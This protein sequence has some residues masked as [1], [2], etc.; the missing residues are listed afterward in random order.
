MSSHN[1][2]H[3]VA[4]VY[5]AFQQSMCHSSQLPATNALYGQHTEEVAWVEGQGG[6]HC[7]GEVVGIDVSEI[8]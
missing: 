7:D 2:G 8:H 3:S 1:S 4:S 6:L 5:G